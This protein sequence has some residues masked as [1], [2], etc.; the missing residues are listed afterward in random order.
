VGD[1]PR[2]SRAD[3]ILLF[4]TLLAL[5]QL[6]FVASADD[7]YARGIITSAFGGDPPLQLK[8]WQLIDARLAPAIAPGRDNFTGDFSGFSLKP[9]DQAIAGSFYFRANYMLWP[10]R[11][12]VA[13][14][15][16]IVT[17]TSQ[18]FAAPRPNDPAWLD[19][20]DVHATLRFLL[21]LDQQVT[22]QCRPR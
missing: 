2:Y 20:H 5:V 15:D 6:L 3:E 9:V 18:L 14:P 10:R 19:A 12:Y 16:Q 11:M 1:P 17:F 13:Y 7:S 8:R 4:I 22:V 21:S